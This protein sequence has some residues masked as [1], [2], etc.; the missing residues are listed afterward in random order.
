MPSGHRLRRALDPKLGHTCLERR[1]PKSK[2]LRGAVDASD[3]PAASF[4]DP[5][6][7]LLLDVHQPHAASERRRWLRRYRNRQVVPDGNNHGALHDIAQLAD[8][9]GPGVAL[10]RLHVLA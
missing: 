10:Q 8:V 4:D 3:A 1:R 5:E 7:V 2:P 6:D 9:S